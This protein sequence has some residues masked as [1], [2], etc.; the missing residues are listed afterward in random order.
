MSKKASHTN[1]IPQ[2]NKGYA[3]DYLCGVITEVS[4]PLTAQN[5]KEYYRFG[6]MVTMITKPEIAKEMEIEIGKTIYRMATPDRRADGTFNKMK[7]Y[8]EK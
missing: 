8:N 7:N 1:F 4:L 2:V 3:N 6:V 5:G